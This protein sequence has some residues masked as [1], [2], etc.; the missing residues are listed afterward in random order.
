MPVPG[1]TV[2]VTRPE[3]EAQATVAALEARGRRAIA[4]PALIRVRLERASP[5]DVAGAQGAILTSAASARALAEDFGPGL[6][7]ATDTMVAYCVGAGTAD[8]ARAAGVAAVAAGPGDAAGLLERLLRLDPAAGPLTLFRGREVATDLAGPLRR[9]GFAIRERRLYAADAA[10]ALS[11]EA[12]A[13][14]KSGDVAAALFL[15]ART[16]EA[17]LTAA[18]A[19]GLGEALKDVAALCNSERTAGPARRS[20]AFSRIV[21]ADAPTLTATLDA[22]DATVPPQR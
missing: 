10:K 21:V 11:A 6:K 18:T 19:S 9:A 5:D 7:A 15:S 8:A 12:E 3:P 2:L 22:L 20:R 1:A 16:L 17:F 14:L 13:A 4:T